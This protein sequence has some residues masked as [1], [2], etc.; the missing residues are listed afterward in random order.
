MLTLKK[1]DIRKLEFVQQGPKS[2]LE[3][4]LVFINQTDT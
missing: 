4:I 1:A 2:L 3:N